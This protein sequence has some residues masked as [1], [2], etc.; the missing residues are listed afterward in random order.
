MPEARPGARDALLDQLHSLFRTSGFD[1]VSIGT[2]SKLTGL[3]KSSLYHYFPGGKDDMALAVAERAGAR[4]RELVIAPLTAPGDRAAR[5]GGMV[6]GVRAIYAEGA[7]PC[8]I[9]AMI[10]TGAPEPARAALADLLQQW[11]AALAA[12]LRET[13]AAPDSA[14][15]RALEAISRIEGALLIA[16]AFHN[17]TLFNNELLRIKNDLDVR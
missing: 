9:A 5:I 8:L 6:A 2:V 13:G 15:P 14:E 17:P 3:G 7:E 1:G 4:L 11:I 16:R 10:A 12:A